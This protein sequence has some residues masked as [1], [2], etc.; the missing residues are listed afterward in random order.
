MAEHPVI[1]VA[2]LVKGRQVAEGV[3][4]LV[5]PGSQLVEK[6][7]KEEGLDKIFMEA[8]VARMK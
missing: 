4:A 6:V 3:H 5:V 1:E 2:Q 8:V 7:A